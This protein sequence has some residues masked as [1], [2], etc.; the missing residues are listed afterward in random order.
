MNTMNEKHA[1]NAGVPAPTNADDRIP[2]APALPVGTA[3]A[4]PDV[5]NRDAMQGE[6]NVQAA[7]AF[8]KAEQEFV[9][10]GKVPAAARAAAPRSEAEHQ[11]M[12]AAEA[13]A[14][15]HAKEAPAGPEKSWSDLATGPGKA[16]GES[17]R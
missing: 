12:L 3:Q 16:A 8:N 10:A 4:S 7:T 9:A 14:K 17:P 15:R 5:P 13:T 1:V 6:G 11:S 2:S